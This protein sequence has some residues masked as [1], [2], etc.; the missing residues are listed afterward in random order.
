MVMWYG[1]HGLGIW[2]FSVAILV[3]D[4]YFG[5]VVGGGTGYPSNET[6]AVV[7]LWAAALAVS[8]RPLWLGG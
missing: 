5:D 3:V 4:L 6:K 1:G 2:W 7:R 8:G